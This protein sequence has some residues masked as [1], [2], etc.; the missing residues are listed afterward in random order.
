MLRYYSESR[1]SD[2]LERYGIF[3]QK[4]GVQRNKYAD[5][6]QKSEGLGLV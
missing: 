2:E 5:I 6:M 4:F 3:A 1:S